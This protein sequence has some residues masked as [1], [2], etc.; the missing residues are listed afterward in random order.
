MRRLVQ[1]VGN[2]EVNLYGEMVRKEV[3]LS[4]SKRGAFFRSGRK[5]RNRAKWT[6][7]AYKGWIKLEKGAGG[8]VTAEVISRSE[9]GDDWQLLHAFIGW[10]D[11]HFG[12]S[13][14]SLNI[15]YPE[16]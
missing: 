14:K 16:F 8:V 6:H 13:I 11:R 7:K 10:I 4:A 12:E 15:Q 1:V 3:E 9:A 5:E 2:S